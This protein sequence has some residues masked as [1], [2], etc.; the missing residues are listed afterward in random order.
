MNKLVLNKID[1]FEQLIFFHFSK[2][3]DSIRV[4]ISFSL[5]N[6]K[7]IIDFNQKN[8]FLQFYQ[9]NNLSI[10]DFILEL[11]NKTFVG[12]NLEIAEID[13]PFWVFIFVN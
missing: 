6:M 8:S 10:Q 3:G 4:P 1:I 7:I 11:I 2:N 9:F 13:V 5:Q 12:D